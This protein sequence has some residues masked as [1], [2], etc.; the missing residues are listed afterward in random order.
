M[1][2]AAVLAP[3]VRIVFATIVDGHTVVKIVH[4][5]QVVFAFSATIFTSQV[6]YA[7]KVSPSVL[8]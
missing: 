1:P 6:D 3:P 2:D 5:L 7:G 8:A 4:H